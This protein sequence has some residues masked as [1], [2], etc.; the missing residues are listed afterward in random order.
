MAKAPDI[1]MRRYLI[2][3]YSFCCTQV[4]ILRKSATDKLMY[5]Y[6]L[7]DQSLLKEILYTAFCTILLVE[8]VTGDGKICLYTPF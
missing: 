8:G 4:K 1:K 6:L 3:F 5:N 7:P 2:K